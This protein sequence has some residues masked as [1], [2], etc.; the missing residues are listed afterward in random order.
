M[1]V[2]E[3]VSL[4]LGTSLK[5]SF[6]GEKEF[7]VI[8]GY[9]E[10]GGVI[11]GYKDTFR[12]F[13]DNPGERTSDEHILMSGMSRYDILPYS[14]FGKGTWESVDTFSYKA[15]DVFNDI[16]GVSSVSYIEPHVIAEHNTAV[17][18]GT[19]HT[20]NTTADVCRP[21]MSG[22]YTNEV[23]TEKTDEVVKEEIKVE[24]KFKVNTDVKEI[25]KELGAKDIENGKQLLQHQAG[26]GALHMIRALGKDNTSGKVKELLEGDVSGKVF[27]FIMARGIAALVAV[28][29]QSDERFEYL[30]DG[31]VARS[32]FE[33]GD[34]VNGPQ[35]IEDFFKKFDL[36]K[37]PGLSKKGTTETVD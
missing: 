23:K 9:T 33:L 11:I 17:I 26:K 6:S 16:T 29:G 4:R 15:P 12:G 2:K 30:A 34:V 25:G 32:M 27:D 19:L 35:L 31:M 14:D 8:A 24:K 5:G 3:F 21:T 18:D 20:T 7:A 10:T 36:D 1:D 13:F 22:G 28:F 37:I